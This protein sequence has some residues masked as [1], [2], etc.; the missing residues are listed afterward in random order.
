MIRGSLHGEMKVKVEERVVLK[1]ECFLIRGRL[2]ERIVLRDGQIFFRGSVV[3]WM[4]F[5]GVKHINTCVFRW[6]LN[7]DPA[8]TPRWPPCFSTRWWRPWSTPSWSGQPFC[9]AQHPSRPKSQ[10][11][12]STTLDDCV[13]PGCWTESGSSWS[14]ACDDT[15]K[16]MLA[17]AS[18]QLPRDRIPE[19]KYWFW[20]GA[21]LDNCY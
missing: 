19:D 8:F 11:S 4:E 18:R 14:A 6:R 3:F 15:D 12:L 1:E 16:A 5:R 17:A 2:H 10:R 13:R 21:G 7:S 9:T 20:A